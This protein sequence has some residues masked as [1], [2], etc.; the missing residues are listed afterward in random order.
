MPWKKPSRPEKSAIETG[1]LKIGYRTTRFSARSLT[2]SALLLG[3]K[4]AGLEAGRTT[5]SETIAGAALP[6]EA[7]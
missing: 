3:R 4:G 1:S 2:L 5:P 6:R 7:G